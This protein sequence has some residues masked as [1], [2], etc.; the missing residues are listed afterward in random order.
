MDMILSRRCEATFQLLT[1]VGI[2]GWSF[3]NPERFLA[4]FRI[5]DF[6]Y[7]FFG[8]DWRCRSCVDHR[9]AGGQI[10]VGTCGK[11]G[12]PYRGACW[13]LIVIETDNRT[14]QFGV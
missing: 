10:L 5:A 1:G 13:I 2:G 6:K 7:Q 3:Q 4:E 11:L 9:T 14:D 8:F 12:N